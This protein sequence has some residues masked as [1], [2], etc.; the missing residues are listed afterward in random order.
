MKIR[1]KRKYM[2]KYIKKYFLDNL[3]LFTTW[4]RNENKKISNLFDYD[5]MWEK[6]EI[7]KKISIIYLKFMVIKSNHCGSISYHS[8]VNFS[9]K[10]EKTLIPL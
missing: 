1:K 2:N 9:L 8:N 6:K 10:V 4:E 7:D 5:V 3:E